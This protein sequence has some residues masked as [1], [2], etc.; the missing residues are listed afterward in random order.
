MPKKTVTMATAIKSKPN[1]FC[2][3]ESESESEN[4]NE[5]WPDHESIEQCITIKELTT[6]SPTTPPEETESKPA[7]DN[8]QEEEEQ[9]EQQAYRTWIRDES[10]NRFTGD[11]V[12]KNIFSSPF[13]KHKKQWAQP[14]FREDSEGWVSIRWSQPQFEEQST[15]PDTLSVKYEPRSE[16]FEDSNE[17]QFPSLLKR[18][19]ANIST[20]PVSS[21]EDDT[22]NASMWAEKI[23]KSLEKAEQ[24]RIHKQKEDTPPRLSFFKS[25]PA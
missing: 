3:L 10:E 6:P 24:N 19:N 11:E 2:V 14:R 25:I 4:E 13:S 16:S 7:I 20:K 21:A 12:K 23:K 22:L 5:S 8:K 18:G 9:K 17:T 1:P 15:E